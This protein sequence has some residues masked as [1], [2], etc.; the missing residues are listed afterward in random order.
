MAPVTVEITCLPAINFSLVNIGVNI[1]SELTVHNKTN[2][3]LQDVILEVSIPRYTLQPTTIEIPALAPRK[4]HVVTVAKAPE[5]DPRD[6][7][8]L[9]APTDAFIQAHM[10]GQ[11]VGAAKTKLLPANAWFWSS[12]PLALAGFVLDKD[13]AV[14]EL[15]FRSRYCLRA[16][17][18]DAKTFA[19]AQESKRKDRTEQMIKALYF[20]LQER[21]SI[22]YEWEPRTYDFDW[23]MIR[24]SYQV[25]DEHEGTCIDL[26]LLQTAALENIHLDPLIIIIAPTHNQQHALVGCWQR[27]SLA[28]QPLL[29]DR[30]QI[31]NWIACGDLLVFDSIGVATG[32][33]FWQC[34]KDG[35]KHFNN[36]NFCYGVDIC[37][38][39]KMDI[40]PLPSTGAFG[41]T[42]ALAMHYA[43]QEAR[44]L[45]SQFLGTAHLLLGLLKYGKISEHL[46]RSPTY[47][48]EQ[49]K[50][51]I[52]EAIPKEESDRPIGESTHV[53]SVLEGARATA[54]KEGS[55]VVGEEHILQALFELN[56]AAINEFLKKKGFS[57]NTLLENL[58]GL[59]HEPPGHRTHLRLDH[60]V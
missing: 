30:Q 56:D 54:K 11:F 2:K 44:R 1:F 18:K 10:A 39:R 21:Y 42:A 27:E 28:P 14:E 7:Y 37:S 53:T 20:G 22:D 47:S 49:L 17:F 60:F 9:R 48:L 33:M 12:H 41:R 31:L 52:T 6:L 19:E 38:A 15:V 59:V 5:L 4:P 8:L 23:Q 45:Q 40:M 36:A 51:E 46:F 16:L 55:P 57:R 26:A 13:E 35:L 50:N 58:S 34:K 32:R 29:T 3:V 24:F 43:R 25:I